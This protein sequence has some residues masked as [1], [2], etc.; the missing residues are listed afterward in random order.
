MTLDDYIAKGKIEL[1]NMKKVFIEGNKK[2]PDNWP[3]DNTD[4]EWAEQELASRF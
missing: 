2:D 4:A 3:L 1:D